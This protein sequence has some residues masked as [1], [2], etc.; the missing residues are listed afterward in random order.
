M[1]KWMYTGLVTDLTSETA[2]ELIMTADMY[3]LTGLK[4]MCE[5]KLMEE[6]D[7]KN[8]IDMLVI[9]EIYK[10]DDLKRVAKDVIMEKGLEQENWKEKLQEYPELCVEVCEVFALMAT[11]NKYID[12]TVT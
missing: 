3:H 10:A 1:I 5:N 7:A 11:L 12:Q 8:A 9:A 4:N 6:V 2:K